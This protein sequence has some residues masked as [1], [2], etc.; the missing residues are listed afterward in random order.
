MSVFISSP[1]SRKQLESVLEHEEQVS[2]THEAASFGRGSVAF[3]FTVRVFAA[4]CVSAIKKNKSEARCSVTRVL[5]S[6][7]WHNLQSCFVLAGAY[8]HALVTENHHSHLLERAR[9]PGSSYSLARTRHALCRPDGN[10]FI[11]V[12]LEKKPMKRLKL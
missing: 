10:L 5:H 4:L 2:S 1:L 7:L 11:R 3:S 6:E 9:L 8:S 12:R